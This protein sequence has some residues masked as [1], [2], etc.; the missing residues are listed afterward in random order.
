MFF[1]EH[2]VDC[3]PP[4]RLEEAENRFIF[5]L[6]ALSPCVAACGLSLVVALRLLIVLASLVVE[7]R[8]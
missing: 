6:V 3:D 2:V 7:H 5:F 1:S 8:L 4:E